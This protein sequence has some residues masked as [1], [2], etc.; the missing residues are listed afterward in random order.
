MYC[1]C[2]LQVIV[3]KKQDVRLERQIME[4]CRKYDSNNESLHSIITEYTDE[5]GKGCFN[6][7]KLRK[8]C[9]FTFESF[10]FQNKLVFKDQSV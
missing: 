7:K 9:T 4:F 5:K 8:H 1:T 2:V 3:R 10:N 6:T